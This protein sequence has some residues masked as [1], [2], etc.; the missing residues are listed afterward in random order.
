MIAHGADSCCL[1]TNVSF[2]IYHI[3]ASC[4]LPQIN[5]Q[6]LH[7]VSALDT[8][9]ATAHHG[10]GLLFLCF[11]D[12][13]D[14]FSTTATTCPVHLCSMENGWLEFI[15]D[16]HPR[17]LD[18]FVRILHFDIPDDGTDKE[19]QWLRG[20]C[21]FRGLESSGSYQQLRS[22]LS[23]LPGGHER[24]VWLETFHTQAEKKHWIELGFV[25]KLQRIMLNLEDR[26]AP[27][28]FKVLAS[29]RLAALRV[30]ANMKLSHKSIM[31]P[32]ELQDKYRWVVV[33]RDPARVAERTAGIERRIHIDV[34]ESVG[35]TQ[36][37][38]TNPNE[39]G[40]ENKETRSKRKIDQRQTADEIAAALVR[41]PHADLEELESVK[42]RH[43]MY[44]GEILD[45]DVD[46]WI[47]DDSTSSRVFS[48]GVNFSE[49]GRPY[50][51]AQCYLRGMSK[52][53]SIIALQARLRNRDETIEQRIEQLK[54]LCEQVLD[55]E[56]RLEHPQTRLNIRAVRK[57][58]RIML[59]SKDAI[60]RNWTSSRDVE[61][62]P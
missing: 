17:R 5:H 1:Q 11:L 29:N 19:V 49:R 42:Q 23:S 31:S 34:V 59:Q 48:I 2:A 38:I 54:E 37:T 45:P 46:V 24:E 10:V 51:V 16:F 53:G 30:C 25:T 27:L 14:I 4:V 39:E 7:L 36:A 55:A 9:F 58:R 44:A 8:T 52:E 56:W 12:K 60:A 40:G 47:P 41:V 32:V 3:L 33:G 18:C 43:L 6:S 35:A 57:G 22:R 62:E 28:A 50:W 20:Q 61:P 13:R 15:A 26:R 21:D